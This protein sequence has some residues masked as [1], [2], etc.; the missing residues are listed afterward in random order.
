MINKTARYC[1]F[2]DYDGTLSCNGVSEEN[3]AALKKLHE[4]G[5]YLF[6]NTGRSKGFI[7]EE[8]FAAADWDGII[9]GTSYIEYKNTVLCNQ[10]ISKEALIQAKRFY[11]AHKIPCLFEGVKTNYAIGELEGICNITNDFETYLDQ[12]YDKM[13]ITKWTFCQNI[14]SYEDADFPGCRNIY[15]PTYTETVPEGFDKA[16]GIR[17]LCER[18]RIP[19]EHTISFGDSENDIEM[20]QYTGI[21]VIMKSAP[22]EF[23]RFATIRTQSDTFGVA[24]AINKLFFE[25]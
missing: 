14:S 24:Q 17:L 2:F 8:A 10:G 6:L 9:A 25:K 18:L 7:P 11:D 4:L 15:H 12:N 13:E 22:P 3:K 21:S 16:T 19:R 23:D 20:L 1:L 5:H